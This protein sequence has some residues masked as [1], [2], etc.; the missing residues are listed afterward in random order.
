MPTYSFRSKETGDVVD[1]IMP[2]SK[3]EQ[4]L[5][6]NPEFEVV[7][8]EAPSLGDPVRLGLRKQDQGFRE[9]LQ[10]IKSKHPRSTI[11]TK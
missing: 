1:K 7:M 5:N 2:F 11:D 4:W 9:V 6:E 10:K 8:M 3:R